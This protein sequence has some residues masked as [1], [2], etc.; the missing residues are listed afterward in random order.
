MAQKNGG[1][2]Y[3]GDLIINGDAGYNHAI[4]FGEKGILKITLKVEATPGRHPYTWEGNNAF[5][6]LVDDYNSIVSLFKNKNIATNNDNWHTTY[7]IYDVV[8]KNNEQ[9]PPHIA[10]AKMNFYFTENLSVS[11]ILNLIKINIKHCKIEQFI[12]SERV[13]IDPESVYIQKTS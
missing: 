6:L 10:E 13:F 7:S 5:E 8:I 2:G 3:T 11:D 12:C 4:I 9:Y 1:A